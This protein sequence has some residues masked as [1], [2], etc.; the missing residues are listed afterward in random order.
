[1]EE[2]TI[3]ELQAAS[4]ADDLDATLE[5]ARRY[6]CGIDVDVDADAQRAD[7]LLNQAAEAGHPD[8][9]NRQGQIY[10]AGVAVPLDYEE[11]ARWYTL[12]AQQGHP[13][14]LANLGLLYSGGYGVPQDHVRGY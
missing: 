8:G 3:D 12:A 10:A 1:L 14:A 5:L 13:V 4:D 11:A 6:A 7:M 9:Q 2:W